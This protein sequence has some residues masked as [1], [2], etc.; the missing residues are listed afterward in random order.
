MPDSEP[1]GYL[2]R[3]AYVQQPAL[4][5]PEQGLFRNTRA[6]PLPNTKPFIPAPSFQGGTVRDQ[7]KIEAP[8]LNASF[9]LL[10][11]GFAPQD[12]DLKIGP[13]YFKLNALSGAM[14]VS[15]NI[16]LTEND[17]KSGTIAIV[18][19]TGTAEAQLT[20]GLHLAVSGSLVYLPLQGEFGFG[21]TSTRIPY[22]LGLA[23]V[24]ALHSQLTWDVMVAGWPIVLA[25]EFQTGVGNYSVNTRDDFYLF[26]GDQSPGEDRAG[27][28]SFRLPSQ[29][30]GNRKTDNT[31]EVQSEFIYFSNE[32]SA[33]TD[34]LLPG[35]I[36]LHVRAAQENLWYNQGGRGLPSLRDSLDV[37]LREEDENMR[38]K[39]F[40]DY[41]MLYTSTLSG[42]EHQILLGV[43]GPITDQLEFRGA[44][45]AV[46]VVNRD[47]T[48]L[49]FNLGLH[50]Q[51]SPYMHETL[52]FDRA[53]SDFGDE[54]DTMATFNVRR[55]LGPNLA[56]NAF[57][58]YGKVEDLLGEFTTRD[59][60]R[61]G[62]RLE[63][64]LGPRTHVELSGIY[65]KITHDPSTD[66]N[67]DTWTA[68]FDMSHRFTDTFY[69]RLLYQY[70]KREAN[71]PDRSYYENLMF[72]SATKYF[73]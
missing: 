25:D 60:L 29:P 1:I 47:S 33:S 39:P 22:S 41:R 40:L 28:Y 5:V 46:Y 30:N 49:L 34:R 69:V 67:T 55:V 37:E 54:L 32:V 36:R 14:L 52:T 71:V 56:A 53:V 10:S 45:G 17:R 24:P 48:S 58:R 42:F 59:E 50:H 51:S 4:G 12:A 26:E 8:S 57:V 38:F 18:R 61:T 11:K 16:D 19:L 7:V 63:V 73:H 13:L 2:P 20:E 15:D 3:E 72:L 44:V 65:A 68:R 70:Q 27:R 21:G 9:P 23:A 62:L 6:I 31:Q 43:T 64:E 35:D 66:S